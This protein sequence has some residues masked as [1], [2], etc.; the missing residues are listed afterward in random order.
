MKTP[1]AIWSCCTS[2]LNNERLSIVVWSIFFA[3]CTT[4][5]DAIPGEDQLISDES[6]IWEWLA[7]GRTHSEQRCSPLTQID[8]ATVECLKP[9]WYLDLPNDRTLVSTPLVVNGTL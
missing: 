5:Q 6:N 8:T 9:D 2:F 4:T 3:G 7:Y 1:S